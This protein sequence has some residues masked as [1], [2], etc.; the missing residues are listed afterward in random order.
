[1]TGQSDVVI[2]NDGM[3]EKMRQMEIM[4]EETEN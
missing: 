3:E 1:M 4:Q 2:N